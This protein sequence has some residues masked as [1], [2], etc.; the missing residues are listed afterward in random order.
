MGGRA[1]K[2]GG[3][4]RKIASRANT[5]TIIEPNKSRSSIH[6]PIAGVIGLVLI[7]VIFS[8]FLYSNSVDLRH[9]LSV[10]DRKV[11]DIKTENAELGNA[12]YAMLDF[13]NLETLVGDMWLVKES[14]REY[15][16]ALQ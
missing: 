12:L 10:L 7:L 3:A 13:K 6:F 5:M 11:A 4:I 9:R 2:S 16:L 1:E 8:V 15:F 14:R